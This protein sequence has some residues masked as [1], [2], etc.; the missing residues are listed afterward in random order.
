[1]VNKKYRQR[2]VVFAKAPVA[3]EVKTRLQP[4]LSPEQSALFHERLVAHCLQRL[5]GSEQWQVELWAGSAHSCWRS[6]CEKYTCEL[7]FQQ[8][9]GLGERLS[10]ALAD[11]LGRSEK[12][13]V[14]GTD[15]PSLSPQIIQAAFEALDKHDLVLGPAEDGGYVL[16]GLKQL[17]AGLFH[18]IDWG[19]ERVLIQTRQRAG[20]L[21]LEC[22][23]LSPLFD[24]D[25]PEDF[26]RLQSAMPVL[27][28]NIIPH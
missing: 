20:N 14:I 22:C 9:E 6:L 23:E 7:F 26:F 8:G 15:C 17:H 1:M 25:R 2:L 10:H 27:T 11:S 24:V 5:S 4:V 28:N 16:L 3:G 13:I 18:N 12:A 19:T 21:Q